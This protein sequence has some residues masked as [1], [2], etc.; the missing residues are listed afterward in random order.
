[1]PLL[2]K[3]ANAAL[4]DRVDNAGQPLAAALAY[5]NKAL[6][7]RGLTFF[8]A[9]D[10]DARHQAVEKTIALSIERLSDTEQQRFMELAVFPEDVDVPLQTLEKLWG[11]T[12]GL[13]DLDTESLS[14]R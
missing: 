11:R 5:I 7:R 13:D 10:A 6:D 4:R 12:G 14:A 1:W 9:R 3:L 8:D 2:L